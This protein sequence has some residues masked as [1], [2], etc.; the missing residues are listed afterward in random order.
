MLER[1]DDGVK[2]AFHNIL[3]EGMLDF[4]SEAATPASL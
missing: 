3:V 1:M 4:L 2:A